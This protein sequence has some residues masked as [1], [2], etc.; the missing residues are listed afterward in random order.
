ML[1][2]VSLDFSKNCKIISDNCA[3]YNIV[4]P[5]NETLGV[6]EFEPEQCLPLNENTVASIISNIEQKFPKVTKNI[7]HG[8]KLPKK[9]TGMFLKSLN[10]NTLTFYTN[11]K[12][13]SVLTKWI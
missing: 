5:R 11:I 8:R 2:W 3:P 10:K 1:A 4:L 7:F 12:W 6:L 13:L 9:P